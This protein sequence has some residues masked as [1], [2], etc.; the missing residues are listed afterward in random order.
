MTVECVGTERTRPVLP[1]H[2]VDEINHRVINEYA[3]AIS[4]LSLAARSSTPEAQAA[5]G[6]AAA[7]LR[8]HVEAHR[9]LVPPGPDGPVNLANYLGELCASLSRASLAERGVR[10]ALRTDEI[11]VAPDT[12][13]RIGLILAELVRNACRHGLDG[14]AGAIAVRVTEHRGI[15]L[16]LVADSGRGSPD[17]RMGRGRRLARAIAGELGGSVDWWF[18]PTGSLARLEVPKAC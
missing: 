18:S 1:L 4:A 8:A 17:S 9:A 2:I 16:C 6:E 14:G 3:E 5:I 15:I 11:R 12:A 13:W 10:I 7:R